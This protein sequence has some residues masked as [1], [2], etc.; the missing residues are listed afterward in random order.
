MSIA[1]TI[2]PFEYAVPLATSLNDDGI[3]SGIA[4]NHRHAGQIINELVDNAVSNF[5]RYANELE[6]PRNVTICIEKSNDTHAHV[7]VV[8]SGTGILDLGNALTLAGHSC[9]ESSL[10]EHGFGLKHALASADPGNNSWRIV[11]RS[12]ED[13]ALNRFREVSAPFSTASGAMYVSYIP[14]NGGLET[15]TG[16]MV[17]FDCPLRLFSRL[18]KRKGVKRSFVDCIRALEEELRFVYAPIIAAGEVR[19]RVISK[20]GEKERDTFLSPLVPK[21]HE[22]VHI[23]K[24][25]CDLGNGVV[26]ISC[27]SGTLHP[28]RE[29]MKY[30]KCSMA[31]SGV[32][33]RINGRAICHGEMASIFGISLHPSQNRFC[34]IVDVHAED[35]NALPPTNS[36]KNGLR[37]DSDITEALYA[38]IRANIALPKK[39]RSQEAHLLDKLA[40]LKRSQFGI[41][42]VERELPA[43]RTMPIKGRIDLFTSGE[44]GV[45]IYEAKVRHTKED[46]V[47][48][49]RRYWDLA[50]ADGITVNRGILVACSHPEEVRSMV[51]FVNSL[52]DPAGRP[53]NIMLRT[54]REEGIPFDDS[55]ESAYSI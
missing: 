53:Y 8:D 23:D 55:I 1:P 46:C 52:H 38:W 10:N 50:V 47:Y 33:L 31:S 18:Y 11:T 17:E 26:E 37:E 39:W 28:S 7:R 35:G 20:D 34:A 24:F 49:L 12:H 9:K 44:M 25:P 40:N 45:S 2:S 5:R 27:S 30:Y 4:G 32:E 41:T 51:E 15:E 29:N 6:L 22:V 14:G 19:I 21:W 3:W 13:A 54:W 42:R 48:Q 36:A 16:T 43:S